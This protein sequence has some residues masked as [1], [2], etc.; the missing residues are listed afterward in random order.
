MQWCQARALGDLATIQGPGVAHMGMPR[1]MLPNRLLRRR[2]VDPAA[3]PFAGLRERG[4]CGEIALS[5]LTFEA[6]LI[7]GVV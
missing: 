6:T 3:H 7:L 5:S 2:A 4:H 1:A